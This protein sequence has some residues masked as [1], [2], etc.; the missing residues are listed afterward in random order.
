MKWRI[1]QDIRPVAAPPVTKLPTS[2][3]ASANVPNACAKA[4]PVRSAS[5]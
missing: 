1:D 3:F 4:Q 2:R 5:R